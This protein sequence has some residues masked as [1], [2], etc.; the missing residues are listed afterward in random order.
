MHL[1]PLDTI[2]NSK[3]CVQKGLCPVR[4]ERDEQPRNIYYEIH[5]DLKASQKLVLI[6]GLMFTCAAWLEQVDHFSRKADHAVLVFDNRGVGNSECGAMKPYRTSGM[7]KDV[8]DLLDYVQWDQDRSLHIFGVSLGGMLSQ[9]LCLL[10]PKRIKSISFVSTRCGSVLD[11]PSPRAMATLLNIVCRKGPY[12]KRVDLL[13]ELL[14]P[15][16]YLNQSTAN[17]QTRRDDL[18]KYYQTW[19]DRPQQLP[20]SGIFGQFCATAFHHCSD[21]CLK[22]IA[23]EL[24]PAKIAVISGNQDELIDPLRSFELRGKL[25]GSELILFENAGHILNSQAP[26]QFN[27]LMERII[28]EGN[29]AF[30][31]KS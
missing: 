13:L 29:E 3:T 10:I 15:A 6:M 17:G 4:H 27:L 23:A 1:K 28:A 8:K 14:Y 22:R 5:G 24:Y 16:S 19:F 21:S 30:Q 9:N 25:P 7:A 31:T 18:L 26:Q 2:L 20:L 11:I 12:K